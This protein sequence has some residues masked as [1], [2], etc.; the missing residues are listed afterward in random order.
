MQL[1][2]FQSPDQLRA[3]APLWDDLWRRSTV[4][5]PSAQAQQLALWVETFAPR[6][7]FRALVVE[8]SGRFLAALPLIDRRFGK[9]FRFGGL[10]SNRW[11][12]SGELL[13][14]PDCE[15]DRV[16]VH[17]LDGC[18]ALP[19]PLLW[20]DL[21]NISAPQWRA[22]CAA[23]FALGVR[24]ERHDLYRIGQVEIGDDWQAYQST[25]SRNHR[26]QMRRRL[27][28]LERTGHTEL[29]VRNQFQG[30]EL[31]ELLRI[32][33]EIEDSGW[34]GDAGTSVLRSPGIFDFYCR[35]ATDLARAGQLEL[36]FLIHDQQ[37]I[38]FEYGWTAKGVYFS[39]KVAYDE[40]FAPYSPGQLLRWSLLR[41]FHECPNRRLVDFLGPLANATA[42][43]ATQSYPIARL[44]VAPR[45]GVSNVCL[46]LLKRLGTRRSPI[47]ETLPVDP[48]E[49]DAARPIDVEPSATAAIGPSSTEY[50]APRSP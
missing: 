39:P 21:V 1:L 6:G 14:D 2:C 13:L 32:G 40:E 41:H 42:K 29:H 31:H 9:L 20:F 23:A 22:F 43:W 7:R 18:A 45:R 25:R 47:A 46:D 10:P 48:L 5:L 11:S 36:A 12:S 49:P 44:V 34:K 26:Q 33:F 17:L 50:D 16:L 38:A 35:Q 28:Q 24:T 27:R 4:T 30:G 19:W 3:V 15:L 8:Q 37:P